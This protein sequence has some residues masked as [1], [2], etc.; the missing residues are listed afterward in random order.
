VR[1]SAI[2]RRAPTWKTCSPV[3][4]IRTRQVSTSILHQR[5]DCFRWPVLLLLRQRVVG[6]ARR[7]HVPSPGAARARLQERHSHNDLQM[8]RTPGVYPVDRQIK[9]HR[10]HVRLCATQQHYVRCGHGTISLSAITREAGARARRRARVH[11][12]QR[13]DLRTCEVRGG[14]RGRLRVCGWTRSRRALPPHSGFAQRLLQRRSASSGPP[15]R[16]LG[17]ALTCMESHS[18]NTRAPAM[19]RSTHRA[20]RSGCTC[21]AGP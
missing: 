1:A 11:P 10:G 20:A 4:E 7:R 9:T 5:G 16:I 17:L 8:A 19:M 18:A 21:A 15:A 3:R 12:R 13:N 2:L 6:A 14:G